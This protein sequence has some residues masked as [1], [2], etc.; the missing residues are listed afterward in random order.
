[1][2]R[3]LKL[4]S[5]SIQI[6]TLLSLLFLLILMGSCTKAVPYNTSYYYSIV[7][8]SDSM[9]IHNHYDSTKVSK[10]D[11]TSKVIHIINPPLTVN[12]KDSAK[13]EEIL[14]TLYQRYSAR[15]GKS[16][17]PVTNIE[18]ADS[19]N[20]E[21]FYNTIYQ[22][23]AKRL[24][25]SHTPSING[26]RLFTH[27]CPAPSQKTHIYRRGD[28]NFLYDKSTDVDT[29][30]Y[31]S[32]SMQ[33]KL[34]NLDIIYNIPPSAQIRVSEVLNSLRLFSTSNTNWT[35]SFFENYL[36]REEE[37][38]DSIHQKI[39]LDS[40][41]SAEELFRNTVWDKLNNKSL[42]K[43]KKKSNGRNLG[44]EKGSA[45][46]KPII[47]LY[48]TKATNIT[49]KLDTLIDLVFTYP[50]Y[51]NEWSFLVQPSGD[52]IDTITGKKYYALFWEGYSKSPP[53]INSG[54]VVPSDSV[55]IFLEEKLNILGL[56]YREAEE[57]ILY[58]APRL[59]QNEYSFVH[60]STNEYAENTPLIITP[61]PDC[62][63]RV[64]MYFKTVQKDFR[65]QEQI[66]SPRE[67]KG[68]TIVEWGGCN[69]DKDI[70]QYQ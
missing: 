64:L 54:F 17:Q 52:I 56:N 15:Y 27:L 61:T 18:V 8:K 28:R 1:M 51:L 55:V 23:I 65:T 58:W 66:L 68:F 48:P 7:V 36:P 57:F 31:D 25:S 19:T 60:F 29:L 9:T 22:Q 26:C 46:G 10:R 67:R 50:P 53:E 34:N 63:I 42:L 45:V 70:L 2:Q 5:V 47:Y 40:I 13:F 59:E 4:H 14:D 38:K 30:I 11:S 69:L 37:I 41:Q 49:V 43:L 16:T 3:A 21:Q 44:F 12:V 32:I 24:P 62:S 6:F 39:I 33:E 20:F 35:F